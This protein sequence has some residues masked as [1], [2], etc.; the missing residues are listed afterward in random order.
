MSGLTRSQFDE[1]GQQLDEMANKI[2][3]TIESVHDIGRIFSNEQTSTEEIL[4][5]T[6]PTAELSSIAGM[7]ALTASKNMQD[8]ANQFQL[9]ENEGAKASDVFTHIGDVMTAVSKNMTYDF[10]KPLANLYGNI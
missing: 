6:K 5:K 7:D 2:G 3:N 10:A 4:A 9:L 8:I 1:M